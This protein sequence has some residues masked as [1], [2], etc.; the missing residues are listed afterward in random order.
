MRIGN[1]KPKVGELLPLNK[2]LWCIE[3]KRC[4]PYRY[5]RYIF[6]PFIFICFAK[7]IEF[8]DPFSLNPVD[9]KKGFFFSK[10]SPIGIYAEVRIIK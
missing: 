8:G 1:F 4:S 10:E 9:K 6:K 3:I 2:W 7:F 5:H